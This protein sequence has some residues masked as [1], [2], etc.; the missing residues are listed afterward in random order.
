MKQ[1]IVPVALTVRDY[2]EALEFETQKAEIGAL[3]TWQ[4]VGN[5]FAVLC[6]KFSDS[7]S[8]RS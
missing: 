3:M 4:C 5:V 1:S 8:W 7:A 6:A 2:D